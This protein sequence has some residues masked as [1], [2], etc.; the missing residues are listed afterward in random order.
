M[1]GAEAAVRIMLQS[2]QQLRAIVVHERGDLAD[3]SSG[4][5][6]I[7]VDGIEGIVGIAHAHNTHTAD[8]QHK[9]AEQ[10]HQHDQASFQGQVLN[11][12]HG[13]VSLTP[14]E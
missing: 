6:T 13:I 14:G 5:E 9:Q 7:T 3:L 10:Y 8:Q 4:D 12:S 11:E 2:Q 1:Q